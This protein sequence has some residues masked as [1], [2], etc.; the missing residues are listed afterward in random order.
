MRIAVLGAGAM[1]SV[2]G[3][4]LARGGA[5]ITLLDVNDAHLEA[6]RTDGL[7]VTLDEGTYKNTLPAMLPEA[8]SGEPDVVLLFTTDI[9]P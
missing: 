8:Y 4:R 3:A 2:F 9:L 5:D 6:I 1:G 7:E